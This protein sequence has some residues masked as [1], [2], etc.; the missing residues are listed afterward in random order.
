MLGGQV[1]EIKNLM[2]FSSIVKS[3]SDIHFDPFNHRISIP[4][5]LTYK[6][7]SVAIFND[8]K[9]FR[10]DVWEQHDKAGWR[11]VPHSR[12][13]EMPGNGKYIFYKNNLLIEHD[14]IPVKSI[15]NEDIENTIRIAFG[16][17]KPELMV[18]R[19]QPNA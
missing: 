10:C 2:N 4:S 5:G 14:D 12:H 8:E 17:Y 9:P 6:W 1:S 13:P 18:V 3:E 7:M 15:K 19:W 16:G 11:F